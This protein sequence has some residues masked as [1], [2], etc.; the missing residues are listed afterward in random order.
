[1]LLKAKTAV[2]INIF[3]VNSQE[4]KWQ[5]I[6]CNMVRRARG[7]RYRPHFRTL[8][9]LFFYSQTTAEVC[10]SSQFRWENV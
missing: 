5:L 2:T 1:M 10:I 9:E 4:S 8:T 7:F 3:G 6:L